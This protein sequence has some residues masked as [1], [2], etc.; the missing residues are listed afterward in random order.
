MEQ[1]STNTKK[2]TEADGRPNVYET[3]VAKGLGTQQQQ[4]RTDDRLKN[5]LCFLAPLDLSADYQIVH[6]TSGPTGSALHHI[7]ALQ[8]S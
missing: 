1:T 2:D 8:I 6:L 7:G 3:A 4:A 5:T